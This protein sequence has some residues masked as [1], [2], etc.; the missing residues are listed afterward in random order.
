MQRGGDDIDLPGRIIRTSPQ[1]RGTADNQESAT[2]LRLL[3]SPAVSGT[4]STVISADQ[5]QPVLLRI[6][7]APPDRRNDFA[8]VPINLFNRLHV[9]RHGR[10]KPMAVTGLINLSQIQTRRIGRL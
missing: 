7:C 2:N 8:D 1:R 10:M 4:E 5:H 9:L 6:L 3:V